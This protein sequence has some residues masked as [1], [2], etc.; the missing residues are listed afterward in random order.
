MHLQY[1]SRWKSK[2]IYEDQGW[3]AHQS[4]GLTALESCSEWFVID[5]R[6][7]KTFAIPLDASSVQPFST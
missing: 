4:V 7:P 6:H 1:I 5:Y 2:M 3:K